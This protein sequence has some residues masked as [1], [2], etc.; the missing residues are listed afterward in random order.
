MFGIGYQSSLVSWLRCLKLPHTRHFPGVGFRTRCRGD[1]QWDFV[2]IIIPVCRNA[3]NSCFADL[4]FSSVC[5]RTLTKVEALFQ[6]SMTCVTFVLGIEGCS[7]RRLVN[8]GNSWGRDC[9]SSGWLVWS[10]T[11][12]L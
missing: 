4:Y 12:I 8:F 1:N 3:V 10:F 11:V 6:V 9:T 5:C 2:G 7:I